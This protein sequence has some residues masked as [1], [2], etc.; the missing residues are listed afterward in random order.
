MNFKCS[1]IQTERELK[2]NSTLVYSKRL[3]VE[4][5]LRNCHHPLSISTNKQTN[6]YSV[7][8]PSVDY[9]GAE[10]KNMENWH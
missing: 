6:K 4:P 8:H 9:I 10:E 2:Y 7:T 5:I 3:L 1:L